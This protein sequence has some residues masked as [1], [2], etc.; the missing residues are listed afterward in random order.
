MLRDD[1]LGAALVQV[2]DDG[3]AVKGL[4]GDEALKGDTVD[5]RSNPH[6]IETMAGQQNKA[7]E[8]AQCVGQ[9]Q[10]FSRHAAFGTADS[11][12][13]RPPFAPCPWRWTLT[14]VASTMAYSMS[15]VSGA[16]LEKP[17]ENVRFDPVA[18]A[19]EN[20]VPVAKERRKIAPRA[21]RPH[22]PKNRFDEA[23]VVASAAPGVRWLT[24]TMRLHLRPLG[25]RQHESFHPKLESQP[26]FRWNPDSQ[27]ALERHLMQE[28]RG[29]GWVKATALTP[30]P[31]TIEGLLSKG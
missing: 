2:G 20:S 23:A 16:G 9:R 24:Q 29:A 4:I 27:Q 28:L 3:I 5:K 14:I 17:G 18:V 22:N 21:S 12:A 19:L 30:F 6:G 31:K 15:G 11:L 26:S 13:L 25:V 1:D 10:N 8:I 7:D